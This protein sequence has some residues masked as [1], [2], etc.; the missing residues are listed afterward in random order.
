MYT[1]LILNKLLP[2]DNKSANICVHINFGSVFVCS[3]LSAL[4]VFSRSFLFFS[5]FMFPL[6]HAC[7]STPTTNSS[8]LRTRHLQTSCRDVQFNPT[9]WLNHGFTTAACSNLF[10]IPFYVEPLL[11]FCK[12]LFI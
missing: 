6:T 12:N 3:R 9:R 1:L 7:A 8:K 2:T 4:F 11:L 5:V 10:G